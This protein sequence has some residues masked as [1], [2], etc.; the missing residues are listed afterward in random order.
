[1]TD[2][3]NSATKQPW[4][5]VA[6]IGG[7]NARFGIAGPATGVLEEIR[8]YA[9]AEFANF[10]D[11]LSV[12]LNDMAALSRWRAFPCAA[13][14]AVAA[15]VEGDLVEF[16]NSPWSFTLPQIVDLLAG[17]D[18]VIINDLVAVGHGISQ[19]TAA[20]WLQIG[21]E[22]AKADRPVSVL[23]VGT[24]LGMCSVIPCH[25]G[26]LVLET[27]GGHVDFA[28]TTGREIAVLEVLVARFGHVSAER[29]VSGHGIVNIYR[30]LAKID[31]Q[32]VIYAQ[33]ASLTEAALSGRDPL[34]TEALTLFC[35]IL[36]SVAGNVALTLGAKGGVYM[37]GG[38]LPRMVGFLRASEF[39]Q[40]FEAKGRFSSYLAAIPVRVVLKDNIGLHGALK[41]L[42]LAG[43]L[44]LSE[45]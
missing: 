15:T 38:I 29:L 4:N 18:V 19:L 32:P 35:H 6:D 45:Y 28:P 21:G 27:E 2:S 36:G 12:F 8:H 20:D 34:A 44:K 40:R 23:G 43:K 41:K 42:E 13:C 22:V 17:A 37:A 3:D 33:T 25:S 5:L 9:V 7:T 10:R 39:R 24:G 31:R 1:L 26:F 30:A 14:V 11:A 16:T